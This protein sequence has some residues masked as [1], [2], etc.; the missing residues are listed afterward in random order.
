MRKYPKGCRYIQAINGEI[1]PK[2]KIT[3]ACDVDD[4]RAGTG[5]GTLILAVQ[6]RGKLKWLLFRG[7]HA[8][9]MRL[10]DTGHDPDP[11]IVKA[12]LLA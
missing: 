8:Q 9:I 6:P 5:A 12:M 11:L 7:G 4:L 1:G 10:I 3:Y 2:R